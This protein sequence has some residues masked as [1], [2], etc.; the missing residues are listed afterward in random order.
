MRQSIEEKRI[1][2]RNSIASAVEH[3]S[4]GVVQAITARK[5]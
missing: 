4:S 5:T 3:A 2:H 1:P